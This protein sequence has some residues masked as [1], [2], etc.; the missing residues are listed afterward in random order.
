MQHQHAGHFLVLHESIEFSSA[1][2]P[3]AHTPRARFRSGAAGFRRGPDGPRQE[4]RL[5]RRESRF[6]LGLVPRQDDRGAG[7]GLRACCARPAGVA[8][9][10]AMSATGTDR[11]RTSS[12]WVCPRSDR[13]PLPA[14]RRAPWSPGL[15]DPAIF[16]HVLGSGGSNY[17]DHP[18]RADETVCGNA[19]YVAANSRLIRTI[20]CAVTTSGKSAD[21]LSGMLRNHRL[22]R[23]AFTIVG[24]IV[25][26]LLVQTWRRGLRPLGSDLSSFLDSSRAIVPEPIRIEQAR[27][28][29]ISI[30]CS[31]HSS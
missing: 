31:S 4:D 18:R 13:R 3:L 8:E 16:C 29:L 14:E 22:S 19:A 24:L 10:S 23:I 21:Q 9:M 5:H 12:A 30:F 26:F 1:G 27:P 11:R 25:V 7:G 17:C 20:I 6:A 15:S 2:A 28:S